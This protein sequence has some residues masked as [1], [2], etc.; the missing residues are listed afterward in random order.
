MIDGLPGN[1][2]RSPRSI[3]QAARL[4]HAIPIS[5]PQK[6][7]KPAKMSGAADVTAWGTGEPMREFLYVDDLA[8]AV[9]F[10]MENVGA[11]DLY[12]KGISHL[13]VGSGQDLRI[14][15][16]AERIRTVVGFE[17]V[18]KF[19]TSKPDGTPRKLMSVDRIEKLGWKHTTTIGDGLERTYRWFIENCCK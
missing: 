19:D 3:S 15:D 12:D 18:I 17:G 16:L 9:V 14:S 13:N 6:A 11:V 2:R 4:L 7:Q 5:N 1:Q 8:E 10:M